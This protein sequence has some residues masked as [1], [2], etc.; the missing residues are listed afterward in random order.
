MKFEKLGQ[1]L[2]NLKFLKIWPKDP[3]GST[4]YGRQFC[5]KDFSLLQG[6]EWLPSI[7]RI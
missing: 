6:Q 4:W 3:V 5:S 1:N 7:Y 2:K